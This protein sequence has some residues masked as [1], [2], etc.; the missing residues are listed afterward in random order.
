MPNARVKRQLGLKTIRRSNSAACTRR[1]ISISS[2]PP[3]PG[4][5]G[6]SS[7]GVNPPSPRGGGALNPGISFTV[8]LRPRRPMTMAE[9]MRQQMK[10]SEQSDN[11]LRKTLMRTLVGQVCI[12]TLILK[13]I[14]I[15]FLSLNIFRI[16]FTIFF[17]QIRSPNIFTDIM[18]QYLLRDHFFKIIEL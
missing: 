12:Y 11:R 14:K 8:P 3:S 13:E 9:I 7:S 4:S 15:Q 10:V 6:S 17:K 18:M 16:W 2:A 5:S 1:S